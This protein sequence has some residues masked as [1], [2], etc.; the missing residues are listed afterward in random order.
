M[1]FAYKLENPHYGEWRDAQGKPFVE[2]L[3]HIIVEAYCR[4]SSID[5]LIEQLYSWFD[6][7]RPKV[8]YMDGTFGQS[9]VFGR[10]LRRW[11]TKKGRNLP[12]KPVYLQ[13]KKENRILA[14]QSDVNNGFILF[15][16]NSNDDV[17]TTITQFS[18]FGK[19]K[20]ND[21]GPDAIA[22]GVEQSARKENRGG[23]MH[24]TKC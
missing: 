13:E 5:N 8:I 16:P 3:Y 1:K 12:V 11:A 15:P 7:F 10:E 24:I 19:P 18:R 17:E 14:L 9:T 22:I 20:V 23:G 6:K 2:G 21:D 4:Q